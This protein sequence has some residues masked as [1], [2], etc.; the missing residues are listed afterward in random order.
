[1]TTSMRF[2]GFAMLATGGLG[3]GGALAADLPI[4]KAP[5]YAPPPQLFT[6]TGFYIGV[7]A[8]GIFGS[9]GNTNTLGTP[10]FVGLGPTLVPGS[11]GTN[12][13]GFI[14]GGQAGYN[15]QFGS[16]VIGL[17]ADFDGTTL[18][19]SASFTSAATVL[20]TT[21]TTNAKAKLDYLGTVRGRLGYTPMDRL[22]IYGTGGLAYGD[23]RTTTSV[24]PNAVAGGLWSGSTSNVRT[25][26]AVGGGLE[27][28]VTSNVTLKGEYLY[29]DLGKTTTN[30]L[31]NGVI[32]GIPALNGIDYVSQVR[33]A[34][35]IVRAGANYKF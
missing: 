8:G 27:Y 32:R 4:R 20:G 25:G 16:T 21:L 30:A 34:G 24:V 6:W 17:E 7:N 13:N 28:A 29:Y 31:G 19:K 12:G 23:V 15:Y 14:G 1:M 26:Y 33:E 5:A 3:A 18:S 9:Q 35:S 22:F 10:G 11:L 2:L